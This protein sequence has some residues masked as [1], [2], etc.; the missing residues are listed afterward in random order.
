MSYHNPYRRSLFKR[1]LLWLT[2]FTA[3]V[4]IGAGLGIAIGRY[5]YP[6]TE[7]WDLALEEARAEAE[8]DYYRGVMSSCV[9]MAMQMGLP[10]E[11]VAALCNTYWLAAYQ[12]DWY[13]ELDI[14]S[15]EFPPEVSDGN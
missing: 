1:I 9:G 13:V 4:L 2:L 10:R 7:P 6:N 12:A 14:D 11:S 15:W 3:T 8:S 5:Y